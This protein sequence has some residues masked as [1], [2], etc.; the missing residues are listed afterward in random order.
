VWVITN[1][2]FSANSYIC[3]T[4]AGN[5]CFI[6]DPGLD[7]GLISEKLNALKMVPK[8]ILCT[9]GHFDHIGSVKK[10]QEEFGAK[11]Y[12]NRLDLRIAKQAN[13]LLTAFKMEQRIDVPEFGELMDD[14]DRVAINGVDIQFIGCPGHTDGSCALLVGGVLFSGDTLYSRGVSLSQLPGENKHELRASIV[15]LFETIDDDVLV[16]PGH[17]PSS[18][19]GRIKFD[20]HRLRDFLGKDDYVKCRHE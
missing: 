13:F 7:G 1:G 19:M 6:V 16:L 15:M 2:A 17:G 4:G 12:I 11:S 8:Y 10:F 5:E 9:H 20:N 3:S 14:G 18:L